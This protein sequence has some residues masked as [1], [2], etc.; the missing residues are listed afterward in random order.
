MKVFPLMLLKEVFIE[1]MN[2]LE[3]I[4][5]STTSPQLQQKNWNSPDIVLMSTESAT[6]WNI[7]NWNA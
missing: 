4:A 1:L 2:L 5:H 6:Y 7:E 3:E